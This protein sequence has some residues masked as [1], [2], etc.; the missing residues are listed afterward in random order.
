MFSP[1]VFREW[2]PK[3]L[4]TFRMGREHVRPVMLKTQAYLLK[5]ELGSD[6]R[7]ALI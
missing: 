6:L 1:V 4:A 3:H 7:L 5:G 2:K